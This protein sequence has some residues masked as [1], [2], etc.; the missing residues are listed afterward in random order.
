MVSVGALQA[1][2]DGL[3]FPIS[4]ALEAF[5]VPAEGQEVRIEVRCD[6]IDFTSVRAWEARV[7]PTPA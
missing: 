3:Y 7:E 5:L 4:T 6:W 1:L 2:Y